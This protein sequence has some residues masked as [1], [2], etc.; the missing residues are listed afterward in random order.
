[1]GKRENEEFGRRLTEAM[2]KRKISGKQLSELTGTSQSNI[3]HY[4]KGDYAPALPLIKKMADILCVSPVW[5]IGI[6]DDDAPIELSEKDLAH[7]R[8]ENYIAEMSEAQVLKVLKF[9]EEYIL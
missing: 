8:I 7:N 1:M 4:K 5:L 2:T 6:G 3:T 9:I